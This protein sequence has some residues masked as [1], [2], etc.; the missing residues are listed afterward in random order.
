MTKHPKDHRKLWLEKIVKENNFS[1]GAEIGVAEGVT[2]NHLLDTCENLTMIGVDLWDKVANQRGVY[3]GWRISLFE[4]HKNNKRAQLY[5][6][7]SPAAARHVDDESLDF[8]FID[9]NHFYESVVKDIK[10][11][12][13]KIKPGGYV[14]GHDINQQGVKRAVKSVYGDYETGPDLIWYVKK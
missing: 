8:V 4:Q 5:F 12:D 1:A 2:F 13:P 7:D 6:E 14:C 3:Q 11:W 9:A 10:A